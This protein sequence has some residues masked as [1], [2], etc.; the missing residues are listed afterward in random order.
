MYPRN[1]DHSSA[2]ATFTYL[3][4]FFF[5][6]SIFWLVIFAAGQPYLTRLGGRVCDSQ[7]S[8][9][10]LC[11]YRAIFSSLF[12]PVNQATACIRRAPKTLSK[13]LSDAILTYKYEKCSLP[14]QHKRYYK[15]VS[16]QESECSAA[17]V[18]GKLGLSLGCSQKLPV[19]LRGN[20]QGIPEQYN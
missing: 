12:P 11:I 18:F 5:L 10:G 4:P 20:A 6:F 17:L 19:L 13:V 8:K 2:G 1:C 7:R 3:S 9:S 15:S 16:C 14:S